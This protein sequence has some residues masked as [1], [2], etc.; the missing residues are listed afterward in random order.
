MFRKFIMVCIWRSI[1]R[2]KLVSCGMPVVYYDHR[3]SDRDAVL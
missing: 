3:D 1:D 2:I